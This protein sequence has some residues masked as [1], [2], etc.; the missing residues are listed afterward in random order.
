[1][2][3]EIPLIAKLAKK[4]RRPVGGFLGG[5]GRSPG[6]FSACREALHEPE[7]HQQGGRPVAGRVEVRQGTDQERGGTHQYEGQDQGSLAADLVPEV[8]EE[9]SAERAGHVGDA[10]GGEGGE[11]GDGWVTRG[12]EDLRKDQ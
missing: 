4:P 12:E 10:E 5:Q 11:Q 2:P 8:A 9:H 1:M 7:Q 6:G 3:K